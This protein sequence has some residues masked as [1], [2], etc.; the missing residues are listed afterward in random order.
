MA[1]T[2]ISQLPAAT[3]PLA[4]TELVPIVQGGV[5]VKVAAQN[6][7]NPGGST[8][9]VQ[10]NNAGAF[11]GSANLTWD[12][13]NAQLGATGALRFA[14][15]DSSN[16]VAF[17]APTIVGSNVTWTLPNTDGTAGQVLITN[18]SGVL[19]WA[20]PTLTPT[21]PTNNTL[22]VVSGTPTVGETLSSTSGT[23]SGYPAPT[24]AYQWVRGAATNIGT[25]SPSYQLVDA[26]LGS[27]VKCTVTATNVAG[28]ASA[29]SAPTS[30]IAAGPPQAPTGVTATGGNTQATI[31][32]TAPAITGGSTITSY[33]VTC[34]QNGFTASGSASP[35]TVTGLTNGTSYTFTVTAT[36]AIG[37]GPAGGP[38]NAVV[39]A[40]SP[41]SVEYLVVGGGGAGGGSAN[42][43]VGSGAGAGGYRTSASFS[44]TGGTPY[45]VTV[46]AFGA[47]VTNDVG[48][49]G[50]ASVFSTISSAGGGGGGRRNQ[51]A[52]SGG[53]GGGSSYTNG[54]RGLGNTPSTSPS[55]GNNGATGTAD[56][57][58]GVTGAGGG[59]GG[60]DA[61]AT[62]ANGANGTASSI[63]GTSTTY[64]AG[65]GGSAYP[66]YTAGT[67]G[68]S[69]IGG[70]G[71]QGV[72][73]T[74]TVLGVA[75]T[76]N[77]GGGG[78]GSYAGA[79]L[80]AAG[81]N[82]GSGVVVIAFPDSFGAPTISGGLV[83]DQPT[84]SGYRVY[85]FTSGTG[86]ITF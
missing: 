86:T 7:T 55:Q 51:T 18:G 64:A 53:S 78:G 82:G 22:P 40:N 60:A 13:T 27:T 9:Q 59:G 30:T 37:T 17:K 62:N 85:R 63:T 84:R 14:D 20:T 80:F 16:Y 8:T 81:A 19:S 49:N 58:G 12:G 66:G 61:A 28:S 25:N 11:G 56:S 75:G 43:D 26:D 15:S 67:G 65:G 68:S 46:G 23:W 42:R 79:G 57:G 39:P 83:Y 33:T 32:F 76:T 71:G 47:G 3:T 38:S 1:N 4:G 24:F 45:T 41:S 77:R 54:T 72:T 69:G 36:N 31:S 2:K 73:T 70:A 21:A 48:A 52:G 35:L 44:V 29:T 10:F 50:S 34:V 6:V 5:T 74:D